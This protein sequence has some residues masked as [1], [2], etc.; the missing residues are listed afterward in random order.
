MAA[1][2]VKDPRTTTI[3]IKVSEKEKKI[4]ERVSKRRKLPPST[5][6]RESAI[7]QDKIDKALKSI[8]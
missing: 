8:S 1:N 4:I 3:T 6:M 5:Y 2:K 7:D